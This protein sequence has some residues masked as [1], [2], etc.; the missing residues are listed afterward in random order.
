[1]LKIMWIMVTRNN[2]N[3]ENIS[4]AQQINE[5][6]VSLDLLKREKNPTQKDDYDK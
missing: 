6:I 3:E 5:I 1:M 2:K 4:K